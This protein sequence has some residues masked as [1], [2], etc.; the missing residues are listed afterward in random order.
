MYVCVFVFSIAID[1]LDSFRL[2]KWTDS[3][4]MVV[5]LCKSI[6]FGD[7]GDRPTYLKFGRDALNLFL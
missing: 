5:V 1:W 4:V 7:T 6:L 3:Y 2:H